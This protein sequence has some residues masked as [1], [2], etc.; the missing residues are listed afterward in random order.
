[1]DT[2]NHTGL[3]RR[4][5][6]MSYLHFILGSTFS[7][8]YIQPSVLLSAWCAGSVCTTLH[9][10]SLKCRALLIV[11]IDGQD[12]CSSHPS[13]EPSVEF[14]SSQFSADVLG[15]NRMEQTDEV[16]VVDTWN[17]AS[18]TRNNVLD[19]NQVRTI[20]VRLVYKLFL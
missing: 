19:P 5:E 1:M 10:C 6:T 7:C 20:T 16:F 9:V 14:S 8:P 12:H 4:N 13:P 18:P 17:P 3:C 15:C 2:P 11:C